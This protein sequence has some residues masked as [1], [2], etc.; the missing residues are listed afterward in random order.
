M[1]KIQQ[2][3]QLEL[4]LTAHR[5]QIEQRK[6]AIKVAQ[7]EQMELEKAHGCFRCHAKLENDNIINYDAEITK[8]CPLTACKLCGSFIN[9]WLER[10]HKEN[11]FNF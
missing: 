4:A 7:R 10:G 6:L 9:G 1:K 5:E 2:R 8:K 11:S 3:E